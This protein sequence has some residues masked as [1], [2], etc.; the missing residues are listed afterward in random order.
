MADVRAQQPA[1][2]VPQAHEGPHYRNPSSKPLQGPVAVTERTGTQRVVWKVF[3]VLILAVI[4]IG[5]V[6]GVVLRQP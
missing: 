4:A 5:V 3:F 6:L 1:A 2:E